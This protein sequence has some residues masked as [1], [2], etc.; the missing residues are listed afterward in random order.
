MQNDLGTALA[1][2]Q[3]YAVADAEVSGE[4]RPPRFAAL[5]EFWRWRLARLD[6]RNRQGD[7]S[8]AYFAMAHLGLGDRSL[9]LKLLQQA[10]DRRFCALL[11]IVVHDPRMDPL[12]GD[13]RFT[14]LLRCAGQIGG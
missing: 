13:P 14:R 8:P 3:A 1:Q 10:C 7:I 6:A 12:R 5:G 2:A 9:T 11:P 4:P